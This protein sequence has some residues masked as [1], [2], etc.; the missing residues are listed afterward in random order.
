[1]LLLPLAE[2]FILLVYGAEYA[3]SVDLF[4]LLLGVVIFDVWPRRC[5]CWRWRIRRPHLLAAADASRALTVGLVGLASIPALGAVGAVV[6]RF[7]SH[8]IGAAVVLVAL[9]RRQ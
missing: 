7:A 4:R 9:R 5:C 3:A 8:V 6:A 1:M 2:P